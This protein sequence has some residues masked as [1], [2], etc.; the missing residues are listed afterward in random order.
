MAKS[1]IYTSYETGLNYEDAEEMIVFL[2]SDGKG[3]FSFA[4]DG[5]YEDI[6]KK[7]EIIG[8]I[9][10]IKDRKKDVFEPDEPGEI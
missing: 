3:T 9:N 8:L 4:A 2:R 1:P 6:T 7:D 5:A 10:T